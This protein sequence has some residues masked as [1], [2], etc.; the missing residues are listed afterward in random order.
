MPRV[1]L[2][3]NDLAIG[4]PAKWD[5]FDAQGKVLLARGVVVESE[6]IL[7]DLL[8]LHG[9]R[10]LNLGLPS[11]ELEGLSQRKANNPDERE[12]RMP[13]EETRIKPGDLIQLQ[14]ANGDARMAVKLIGYQRGRSV[15]VTNPLQNGSPIFLREG[16]LFVARVFSGQ[17]AFAFSC[18]VLTNPVKPY[19]HVH[20]SYPSDVAGIKVRRGER[21]RLRVIAALDIDGGKSGSGVFV[22]LSVGG[23]LLLSRSPDIKPGCAIVVKF[24][25]LLSGVEYL[26]ELPGV[27]RSHVQNQDEAELGA[28][29]GLQFNEVS[30]EDALIISAFVFQ[31]LAEN[32]SS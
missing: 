8:R 24:K 26:L 15:I 22:N 13:L 30:P 20:F 11:N 1:P 29:Y 31:Q 12:V 7:H 21:V 17:L 5:V 23:A 25:L 4:Q 10:D 32:K 14:D 16:S 19:P 6:K 27:V 18:N 28:G 3:H 2:S 9:M